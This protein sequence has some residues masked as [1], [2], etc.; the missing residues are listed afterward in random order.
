MCIGRGGGTVV[1]SLSALSLSFGTF[2][3]KDSMVYC[4]KP[5]S[6]RCPENSAEMRKI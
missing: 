3:F 5:D 1:F 2:G 4:R 6:L